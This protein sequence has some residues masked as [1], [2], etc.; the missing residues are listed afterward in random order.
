MEYQDYGIDPESGLCHYDVKMTTGTSVA[1][2]AKKN[3]KFGTV[4]WGALKLG[5]GQFNT[6]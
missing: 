1:A 2:P 3:V 6:V 5:Y 4:Q